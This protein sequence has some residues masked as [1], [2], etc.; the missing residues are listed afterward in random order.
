MLVEHVNISGKGL[1][2]SVQARAPTVKGAPQKDKEEVWAEKAQDLSH[3]SEQVAD[4]QKNLTMIHGVDVQFNVHKASGEVMVTVREESTGRVIRE[5][6]PAEAL[7]LAA[8]IDEMVG[9]IFDQK[10]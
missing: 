2:P 4:V 1:A 3:L 6:P 5:I 10:G 8:K 9:L 7:N